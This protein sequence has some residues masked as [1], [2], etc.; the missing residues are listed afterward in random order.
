MALV[1]DANMRLLA[2]R[3]SISSSRMSKDYALATVD[4]IIEAEAARGNTSAMDVAREF[5]SSPEKLIEYFNLFDIDN[6][7]RI[8]SNMDERTKKEILPMLMQEDLVMGLYFFTQEKL[9]MLLMDVDIKE[10]V[11][12]VREAF[13]LD[14]LVMMYKEEDIQ[15]FFMHRDLKREDVMEQI[16]SLP[17]E[18]LQKFIEGVT[19]SPMSENS[20]SNFYRNLDQL[21]DD[22]FKEF[23]SEIDPDVQRQLVFQLTKEQ[24][25]YLTLFENE[26]YVEMLSKMFKPDMIKPMYVLEQST[27]VDMLTELPSELMS[28][29]GAQVDTEDFAK[30][31][32]DGRMRL[33]EGAALF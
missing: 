18:I 32:L 20:S 21:S 1:I 7:F 17:P 25:E 31:L 16:K 19:G 28:I 23:M 13:P 8:I 33:L 2:E 5:S 29:V 11:K 9:L 10:L 15:E 12:V 4:E 30:F 22:K 26:T 6:K 24:P 14:K 27:L 3:M